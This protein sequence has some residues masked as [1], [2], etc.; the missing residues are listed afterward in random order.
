VVAHLEE[1]DQVL[2]PDL[3][4]PSTGMPVASALGLVVVVLGGGL[5]SIARAAVLGPLD[6]TGHAFPWRLLV[7]NT[8]GAFLLG[9]LATWFHR[10]RPGEHLLRLFCTTGILGGWTTYSSLVG[11]TLILGHNGA[12]TTAVVAVVVSFAAGLIAAALG[13][14]L[15]GR[16]LDRP[17]P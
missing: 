16:V 3:S 1:S 6:V 14:D 15:T 17:E 5:G 9:I 4:E 11:A 8:L 12:T 10:R 2:D 13:M 7:V